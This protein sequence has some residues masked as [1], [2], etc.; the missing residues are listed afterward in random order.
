MIKNFREYINEGIV[1]KITPD[2]QRAKNLI[3]DSE[4]K[5]RVLRRQIK[6]LGIDDEMSNEYV[7]ICYDVLMLFIRAKMLLKGYNSS[8]VGAHEAEVSYLRILG[9]KEQ[10]VQFADQMRFFR[11]GMLYY[12]TILDSVYAKK[13][14][15]FTKHIYF[16]LKNQ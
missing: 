9:F 1:R 8:G 11:N 12:G 6:N 7:I 5:I 4:R 10:E 13:V 14:L 16:K 15:E 2:I 3:K